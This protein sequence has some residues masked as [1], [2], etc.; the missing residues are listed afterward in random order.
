MGRHCIHYLWLLT[1]PY[2]AI[3]KILRGQAEGI[4]VWYHK[5]RVDPRMIHEENNALTGD[6]LVIVTDLLKESKHVCL[7]I[8]NEHPGEFT[9]NDT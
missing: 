4:F 8:R 1:Q 7:Y 2:S 5:E 9:I 3:L 6:E